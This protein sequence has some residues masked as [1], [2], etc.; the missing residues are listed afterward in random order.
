MVCRIAGRAQ[1]P[2]PID[3]SVRLRSLAPT[4]SK[5]LLDHSPLRERPLPQVTIDRVDDD[6][7]HRARADLTQYLKGSQGIRWQPGTQLWIVPDRFPLTEPGGR[8]T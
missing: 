4:G 6:A 1:R 2:E 8:P 7:P 5:G 3:R